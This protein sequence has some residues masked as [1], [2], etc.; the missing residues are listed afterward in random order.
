MKKI[1]FIALSSLVMLCQAVPLRRGVELQGLSI[2]D[3]N[4]L[5]TI[6]PS[7]EAAAAALAPQPQA[8]MAANLAQPVGASTAPA[9]EPKPEHHHH[10]HSHHKEN[11]KGRKV[12][13]LAAYRAATIVKKISAQPAKFNRKRHVLI[14]PPGQLAY[15]EFQNEHSLFPVPENVEEEKKEKKREIEKRDEKHHKKKHH[16]SNAGR[17]APA[18]DQAAIQ[19]SAV[20][21]AAVPAAPAAP[22]ADQSGL[23]GALT[24][25]L[26]L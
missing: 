13:K 10:H 3:V 16:K 17:V 18:T 14:I 7:Q 6:R 19:A 21:P 24:S 11:K 15:Q 22:P 2:P 4:N 20:A 23:L 25:G 1:V 5:L 9:A 12:D 8:P 26:H